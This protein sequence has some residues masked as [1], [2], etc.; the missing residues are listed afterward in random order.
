MV[1]LDRGVIHRDAGIIDGLVHHAEWVGL[2]RPLEIVDGIRPVALAGRVD[3][4]DGYDLARLRLRHQLLVMEAPPRGRVAAERLSRMGGVR[5]GARLD[6]HDPQLDDVAGLGAAHIDRAGA[7]VHTEALAGA[8]P[9]QLAVDRTGAA[10]VHA[11]LVLGPQVDAL[12][13]GVTLDHPLGVVVGVMGQGFD[14]YVVAGIDL[15]DGFEQLAEIAPMDGIGRGRHVMVV[16]LTLPRRDRLGGGRRDQRHAAGGQRRR[17]ASGHERTLQEAAPF[18]VEI[19]EQLLAVELKFRAIAIIAC[20]H[21]MVSRNWPRT[22]RSAVFGSKTLPA[23]CS[24]CAN[25]GGLRWPVEARGTRET[26]LCR[27]RIRG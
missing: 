9:Q 2:R 20:T 4:V 25:S 7:D 21:W 23:S 8:A 17:A 18:G 12:G 1:F 3:L 24:P 27:D 5:T 13:A 26:A 15:D 16:R 19:V 14:G 11:F 22:S 6:V 10:P